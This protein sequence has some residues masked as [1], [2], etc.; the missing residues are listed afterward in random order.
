MISGRLGAVQGG[1]LREAGGSA[2]GPSQ[3]GWG[4]CGGAISGRL[5]AVQGPRRGQQRLCS[6]SPVGKK[7]NNSRGEIKG[8]KS[9]CWVLI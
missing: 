9:E 5:G 3:G 1:D 7:V 4:Q 2:E 8:H 6:Q